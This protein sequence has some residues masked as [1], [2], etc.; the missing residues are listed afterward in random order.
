MVDLDACVDAR[1]DAVQFAP[2]TGLVVLTLWRPDGVRRLAVGVGPRV[3]GVGF[4]TRAPTFSV[5]AQHP[6]VAAARAHL[7]ARWV[8]DLRRDPDDD[9]VWITLGDAAVTARVRVVPA[10]TGEVV[11]YDAA[12]GALVTWR[13]TA[14]GL[15]PLVSDD[16]DAL[17]RMSD[18]LLVELRRGDV[19]RALTAHAKKL[20]RRREAVLGDLARV[21]DVG[22]LQRIGRMLLAQGSKIA[23]GATHAALDDWE[24]GGTLVVTL[25]PARP[26]KSQAEGFFA[27]AKRMAS[28]ERVMRARL[29][30]TEAQLTAVRALREEIDGVDEVTPAQV[31]A[32]SA[33]ARALGATVNRPE[34]GRRR[35][36]QPARLPY[37]EY[38]GWKGH[39]V[40]VGRGARDNDALTLRVARPHDVWMHAR[41]VTGAHVVVPLEKGASC[42]PEVLI[43]AATLAAHHS[44]ARGERLCEVTWAERRYVRKPRKSPPGLVVIDRERVLSLRV[45]DERL[46]RLLAARREG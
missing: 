20:A 5:G 32:W 19:V 40:L 18:A 8:R 4:T 29:D 46:A 43:D 34:P 35:G 27:E 37:I 22:R 14:K 33:A 11:I 21:E 45:D 41:G 6:V 28:G 13:A 23:R 39:R 17:V 3:V 44:D 24:E 26:A 31:E 36:V 38:L 12:G 16:G 1:V 15:R 7:V 9:A 10:P 2:D 25:D 42:P 30:A